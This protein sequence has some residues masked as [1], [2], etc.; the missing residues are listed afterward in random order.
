MKDWNGKE[1]SS[2]TSRGG[3][4]VVAHPFDNLMRAGCSPW[5]TPEVLQKL[6]QSRQ[7]RAFHDDNLT[8][9]KSG[10]GYYCDLQSLHS[11][12]A[13]TWSVF[14]TVSRAPRNCLQRWVG[15]VMDFLG[16][17][18]AS[19][20]L[21]EIFL[22]RR[23]PHPD[24]LVPGGP[25]I[26]AG[27]VTE[28][29]V[30][31]WEAKWLSQVG[32]AQGKERD[33]DQIQLRREFLAKYGARLFPN[34]SVLAVIGVSLFTDC[35]CSTAPSNVLFMSTTWEDL[36]SLSSHPFADEVKRYFE[37]KRNNSRLPTA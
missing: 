16:I 25:E 24:T 23:I 11:E 1:I 10:I 12:D 26:D 17:P 32:T 19:S 9:C 5:P 37:W 29:S 7:V 20:E 15:D 4:Q 22:W 3:V 36:C 8:I 13:I 18:G 33:K 21:S 6:Y 31:F 28:N 27:I 34:A 30:I 2:T 35:F 14:G